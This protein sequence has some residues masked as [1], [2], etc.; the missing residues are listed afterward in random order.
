MSIREIGGG[1]NLLIYPDMTDKTDAK[2]YTER[3]L[4]TSYGS[5]VVAPL[6]RAENETR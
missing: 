5:V 3:M 4:H 1:L 6:E 2:R